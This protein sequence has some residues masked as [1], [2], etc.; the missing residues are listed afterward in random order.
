VPITLNQLVD[1]ICS[2]DDNRAAVAERVRHWSRVGVLLPAGGPPGK[3]RPRF[4][5]PATIVDAALLNGL[6]DI[7]YPVISREMLLAC[8]LARQAAREWAHGDRRQRWLELAWVKSTTFSA[9]CVPFI[10]VDR[11]QPKPGTQ[12]A[13]IL[14][15][16]AILAR[17][18]WTAS[19]EIEPVIDV[20]AE[21][22]ARRLKSRTA[23]KARP[24][25]KRTK[26]EP[27]VLSY[28]HAKKSR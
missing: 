10:H 9:N 4:F 6:A 3:G 15:L 24:K 11:L 7:G 8:E 16:T 28:S 23:V 2:R 5:E 21:P 14:N 13:I 22:A 26:A 12:A 25:S 18:N 20:S 27:A 1:R 17:V 19:D